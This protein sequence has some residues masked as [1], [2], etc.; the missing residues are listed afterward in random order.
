M[1]LKL[2][3]FALCVVLTSACGITQSRYINYQDDGGSTTGGT[4]GG[5]SPACTAA[6]A[7]FDANVQ[8]AVKDT[9]A[10]IGC[11]LTTTIAGGLLSAT[12]SK[13]SRKQLKAY[14]G[15]T[16]DKLNAQLDS[17]THTGGS[18]ARNALPKAKIDAWTTTEPACGS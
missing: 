7:A 15:T 14:T 13:V 2:T 9:C 11:H 17:A 4:T 18:A 12:D 3:S 1:V 8:P 5:D 6:Q 10:Q 16:S